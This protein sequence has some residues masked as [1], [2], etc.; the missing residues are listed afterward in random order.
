MPEAPL[1]TTG[2]GLVVDGEGWFVVNAVESRWK[3]EGLLGRYSTFEGKRRF[4]DLG[5]NVDVLAPGE[6]A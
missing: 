2:N 1:R 5:L 4:P 3:D 6:A